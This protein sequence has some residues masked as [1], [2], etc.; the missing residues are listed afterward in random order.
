MRAALRPRSD[1]YSPPLRLLHWV[2]AGLL[3][4]Q[5]GLGVAAERVDDR[6][7]SDALL[8]AH[9]QLGVVL[10][11]L[12][13]VRLGWRLV[14]REPQAAEGEPAWRRRAVKA[15][16]VGF[17]VLLLALPAS[18]QVIWTWMGADRSVLGVV[19]LPALF[20]PPEDDETGRAIAWYVHV[21]GAWIL[22]ILV[23]IHVAA[24]C[25]HQWILR[26]RLIARRMGW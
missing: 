19:E 3:P 26:D 15:A 22:S 8:G 18:G 10:C 7:D 17:Y 6:A 23:A 9:F 11:L 16:H 1:R 12:M 5:F 4:V 25:W 14:A 2:V 24:A 21:Y 20:T 13:V